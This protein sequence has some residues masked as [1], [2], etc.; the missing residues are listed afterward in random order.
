MKKIISDPEHLAS[1]QDYYARH[2]VL[3][4]YNRL[5]PLLAPLRQLFMKLGEQ[6]FHQVKFLQPL[7][8]QPYRLGVWH[9][10]LQLQP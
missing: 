4:S 5:M 1:L 10:A 6:R 3:P 7:T 8:E 9:P 2:R